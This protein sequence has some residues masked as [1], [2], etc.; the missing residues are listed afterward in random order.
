MNDAVMPDAGKG[1]PFLEQ[2]YRRMDILMMTM[3]GIERSRDQWEALV[4]KV[5]GLKLNRIVKTGGIHEVIE[6][7]K[8]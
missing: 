3:N 7:V 6:I 4:E 5:G 1:D 2:Q 8:V